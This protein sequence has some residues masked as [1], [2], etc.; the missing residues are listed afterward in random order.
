[1]AVQAEKRDPVA[2]LHTT[3]AQSPGEPASA[4]AELSVGE[5]PL[6]AHHRGVVWELL[7]GITQETY[8]SEW[9]IH[10]SCLHHTDCPPS[11]TN[12]CPVTKSG[13]PPSP[14]APQ[15]FAAPSR[16]SLL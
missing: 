13:W 15:P 10:L 9:N 3:L 14:P 7:L 4:L 1:M 5:P 8:G 11:T 12:T 6:S 2:G 16:W